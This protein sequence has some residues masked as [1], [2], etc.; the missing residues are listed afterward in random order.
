[1]NEN[2]SVLKCKN[3]QDLLMMV[4]EEEPKRKMFT[5]WRPWTEGV[6]IKSKRSAQ[7]LEATEQ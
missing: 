1:M 2:Y 6:S 4:A 5:P 7:L 3:L